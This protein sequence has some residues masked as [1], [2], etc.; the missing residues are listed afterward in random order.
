M[1]P[2][3]SMVFDATTIRWFVVSRGGDFKVTAPT[4]QRPSLLFFAASRFPV[5]DLQHQP[6][7]SVAPYERG[8][9]EPGDHQLSTGSPAGRRQL[10]GVY[11]GTDYP[12]GLFGLPREL[13]SPLKRLGGVRNLLRPTG[14]STG[15]ILFF[16]RRSTQSLFQGSERFFRRSPDEHER[17]ARHHV[18][19]QRW[20][21]CAKKPFR[22][23]SSKSDRGD[24]A[25]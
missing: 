10:L 17:D 12:R 18:A 21:R 9:H 22:T 11:Y 23:S 8:Q 13:A 5:R 4:C 15:K 19:M 20:E 16:S 3:S 7:R 25:P 14:M 1:L 24:R 6:N 2:T